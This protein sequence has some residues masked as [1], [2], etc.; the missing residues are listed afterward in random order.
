MD[1][2]ANRDSLIE[3]TDF[4][5]GEGNSSSYELEAFIAI[6]LSRHLFEGYS[7]E[8]ILSRHFP[9][10]IKLAIGKFFPL[11]PYFLGTLYSHLDHFTLDLQHS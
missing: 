3:G 11:A 8:K 10:A 1:E 9:L 5:V 4:V 7:H 6:L 2:K